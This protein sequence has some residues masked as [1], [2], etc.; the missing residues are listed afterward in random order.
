[1]LNACIFVVVAG[2]SGWLLLVAHWLLLVAVAG[3]CL[4]WLD[5]VSCC[6]LLSTSASL[7]LVKY[8]GL[9]LGIIIYI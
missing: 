7:T 3:C 8:I 5:V 1:M 6:G 9:G 2:C 4:L